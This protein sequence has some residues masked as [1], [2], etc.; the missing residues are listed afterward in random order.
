[1]GKVPKARQ[2]TAPRPLE[3]LEKTKMTAAA[4]PR[5]KVYAIVGMSTSRMP[6][7]IDDRKGVS[8]Q[9]CL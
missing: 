2:K 3:I 6:V 8:K 5:D 4:A 1:M 9:K 7:G